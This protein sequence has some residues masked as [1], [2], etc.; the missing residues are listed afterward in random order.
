MGSVTRLPSADKPRVTTEHV[1]GAIV[2]RVEAP[3]VEAPDELRPLSAWA[4]TWGLEEKGLQRACRKAGVP[5]V[6]IGRQLCVRRSDLLPLVDRLRCRARHEREGRARRQLRGPRGALER[7]A[8]MILHSRAPK[9]LA[10]WLNQ[11]R[12]IGPGVTVESY[13]LGPRS[14]QQLLLARACS[15]QAARPRLRSRRRWTS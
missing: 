1:D 7:R 13:T 11:R 5:L 9:S 2:V 14:A 8:A 4:P 15:G 6:K 10:C 12:R 3:R